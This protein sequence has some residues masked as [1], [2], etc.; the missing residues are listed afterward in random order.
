M[1][2]CGGPHVVAQ[3]SVD[4]FATGATFQFA[5]MTLRVLG[6]GEHN[7]IPGGST[8]LYQSHR[9]AIST[10]YCTFLSRKLALAKPRVV[11]T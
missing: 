3:K 5:P 2:K 10:K 4:V 8:G 9:A 11:G 6:G 1:Q 7:N